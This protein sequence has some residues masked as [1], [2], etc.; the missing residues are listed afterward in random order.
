MRKSELKNIIKEEIANHFLKNPD[1]QQLNK[2]VFKLYDSEKI[3]KS[4]YASI[5]VILKKLDK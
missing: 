5:Q 3:E 1:L 2:I 4:E